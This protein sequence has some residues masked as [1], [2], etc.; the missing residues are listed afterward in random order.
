MKE[1]RKEDPE[2]HRQQWVVVG[3]CR[4]EGPEKDRQ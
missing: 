3:D 4:K 1:A 2:N